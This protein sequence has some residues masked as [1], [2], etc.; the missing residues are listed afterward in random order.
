M[1]QQGNAA[2]DI[3]GEGTQDTSSTGESTVQAGSFTIGKTSMQAPSR[4]R[5]SEK[6]R[7][8]SSQVEAQRRRNMASQASS[9][10]RKRKVVTVIVVIVVNYTYVQSR[11]LRRWV[12]IIS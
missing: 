10:A 3:Y 5:V 11:F 6:S 12:H 4:R 8:F 9:S 2:M 1:T 7:F